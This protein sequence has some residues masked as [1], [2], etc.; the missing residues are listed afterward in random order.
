MSDFINRRLDGGTDAALTGA[1]QAAIDATDINDHFKRAD[2]RV[3]PMSGSFYKFPRAEEGSMYTAAPGYLIQSDVLA[4][5]GNILTVRDDTFTV[6]SYGCVRNARRAILAQA[7]CEAVV[8]RTIDFVD[9]TDSPAAGS[10]DPSNNRGS[11]S[12]VSQLSEV[13]RLMGRRF[14]VVSFKWLDAWDI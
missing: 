9:P 7:W 6:R 1:L 2:F 13:N 12:N 3:T 4:S 5:L 10:Y 8:Q 14:R 11:G